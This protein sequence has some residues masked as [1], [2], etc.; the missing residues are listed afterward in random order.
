VGEEKEGIRLRLRTQQ[1]CF[2]PQILNF[3]SLSEWFFRLSKNSSNSNHKLH[4]SSSTDLTQFS[5]SLDSGIGKQTKHRCQTNIDAIPRPLSK[6]GQKVA[7]SDWIPTIFW[8]GGIS[9]SPPPK[10]TRREQQSYEWDTYEWE[11]VESE[12]IESIKFGS[13]KLAL[14]HRMNTPKMGGARIHKTYHRTRWIEMAWLTAVIFGGG[15][16]IMAE[17]VMMSSNEYG[18]TN[19][20]SSARNPQAN[21]IVERIHHQTIG[22]MLLRTMEIY[23]R[24]WYKRSNSWNSRGYNV[25]G[26]INGSYNHSSDS[27]TLGFW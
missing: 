27:I 7:L 12:T 22:N 5:L 25:C 20:N 16:E 1:Q 15:S 19:R 8:T 17:F 11:S 21:A 23:T 4:S 18:L 3:H 14:Q 13:M 26:E 2:S 24:F 10:S 6:F 9:E